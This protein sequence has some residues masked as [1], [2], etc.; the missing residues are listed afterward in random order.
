MRLRKKGNKYLLLGVKSTL[1][2]T[3]VTRKLRDS[4]SLSCFF[5]SSEIKWNLIFSIITDSSVVRF[6]F[7]RAKAPSLFYVGFRS[8]SLF[9]SI[10]FF[11][12]PSNFIFSLFC[13]K[14]KN[15][16]RKRGSIFSVQNKSQASS[17]GVFSFKC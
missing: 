12:P 5:I 11:Y 15:L 4:L 1:S 13:K 6:N 10:C 14:K 8:L 7:L 2:V 3:M 17:I 16:S 9:L